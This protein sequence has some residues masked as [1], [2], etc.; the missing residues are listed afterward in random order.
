MNRWFEP[1]QLGKYAVG[2]WGNVTTT[3]KGI[4]T[5]PRLPGISVAISTRAEAVAN[6]GV[7]NLAWVDGVGRRREGVGGNQGRFELEQRHS[8]FWNLSSTISH[9]Q[10][11]PHPCARI[12][13]AGIP[14][15]RVGP[16]PAVFRLNI[17]ILLV[18]VGD[19]RAI[20]TSIPHAIAILV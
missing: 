10:D 13:I 20:V 18:F 8:V 5:F 15:V 14:P 11:A 19:T 1:V 16:S 17:A 7:E 2:A 9:V 12:D 3:H 4:F 6:S